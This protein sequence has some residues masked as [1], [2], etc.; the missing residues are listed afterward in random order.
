MKEVAGNLRTGRSMDWTGASFEYL[1]PA[2][3]RR[4]GLP[5]GILIAGAAPHTAAARA[6]LEGGLLVAVNGQ[7]IDNSLGSYCD[8][9]QSSGARRAATFSVLSPGKAKPRQVRLALE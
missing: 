2:Q 7:Q 5:P 4:R 8:A 9:M 1:T 3:L 6:G